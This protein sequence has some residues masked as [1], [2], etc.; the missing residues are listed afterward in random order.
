MPPLPNYIVKRVT[1]MAEMSKDAERWAECQRIEA[2][3]RQQRENRAA[4]PGP[5]VRVVDEQEKVINSFMELEQRDILAS[6]A[7]TRANPVQFGP[8]QKRVGNAVP[9]PAP[10]S[11]EALQSTSRR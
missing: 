6:R 10:G 4:P 1:A 5:K 11:F 9:L 8:S 3:E 7:Q 2:F